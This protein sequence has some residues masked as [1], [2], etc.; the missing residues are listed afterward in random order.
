MARSSSSLPAFLLFLAFFL[1]LALTIV[2]FI[3][4]QWTH[5]WFDKSAHHARVEQRSS[6]DFTAQ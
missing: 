4:I 6:H 5:W 2:A 3:D 1:G